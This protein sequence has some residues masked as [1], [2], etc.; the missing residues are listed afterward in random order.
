MEH[1]TSTRDLIIDA[2]RECFFSKGYDATSIQDIMKSLSLS[3][4]GIYHH[5]ASKDDILS[6]L[7]KKEGEPLL[8]G[9]KRIFESPERPIRDKLIEWMELK[10]QF[11]RDRYGLLRKVFVEKTDISLRFR[12]IDELKKQIKPIVEKALE[13]S[14]EDIPRIRE[15]V[16][17]LLCSHELVFSYG[18]SEIE[19]EKEFEE[20]LETIRHI[21]FKVFA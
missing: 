13:Q 12:I 1:Q 2:A 14:K 8:A 7:I 15:T 20:C 17:L 21:F 9:A 6:A 11:Y 16:N 5:F 19:T 3:K 4:G 18:L 10:T